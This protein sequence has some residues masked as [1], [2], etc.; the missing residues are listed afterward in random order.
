MKCHIKNYVLVKYAKIFAKAQFSPSKIEILMR[1]SNTMQ[2]NEPWK[3]SHDT[4]TFPWISIYTLNNKSSP[5]GTGSSA[6][7]M[8]KGYLRKWLIYSICK[9]P[10]H[11]K[12]LKKQI[13]ILLHVMINTKWKNDAVYYHHFEHF[14][15]ILF[16]DSFLFLCSNGLIKLS[17]QRAV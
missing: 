9:I 13:I 2:C 3:L 5:N 7:K 10:T 12:S 4:H 6:F 11:L 8:W 14:C 15:W 1:V 17:S 16:H